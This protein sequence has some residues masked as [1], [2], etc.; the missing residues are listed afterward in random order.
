M[1][2]TVLLIDDDPGLRMLTTRWLEREG[3]QVVSCRSAKEGLTALTETLPAAVL[4]DLYLDDDNGLE[5]LTR[6]HQTHPHVPIIM[7]TSESATGTVVD[8]MKAG[9]WDYLTKPVQRTK[10]CTTVRNA[11]S[12]SEATTRL[13]QL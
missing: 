10:L 4:L 7:M 5:V 3:Y 9:A 11:A 2:Q 1:N 6:I 8:A 13:R 12:L